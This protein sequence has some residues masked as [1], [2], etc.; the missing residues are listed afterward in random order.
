MDPAI[1]K[2]FGKLE[3]Q[4]DKLTKFLNDKGDVEAKRLKSWPLFNTSCVIAEN[5]DSDKRR[6]LKLEIAV[7]FLTEAKEELKKFGIQSNAFHDL[8]KAIQSIIDKIDNMTS[9]QK[10][11]SL[12]NEMKGE[13]QDSG[14]SP[15]LGK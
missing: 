4:R 7:G 15:R 14:V 8:E 13:T 3:E 1:K 6:K 11:K 10:Y 5:Y 2:E 9:V 12:V